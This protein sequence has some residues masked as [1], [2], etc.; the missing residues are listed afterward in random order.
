MGAAAG[1]AAVL[2]RRML[3]EGLSLLSTSGTDDGGGG[4]GGGGDSMRLE[5]TLRCAPD[6][7]SG[8][9]IKPDSPRGFGPAG[10][11]AA[12]FGAA[13]CTAPVVKSILMAGAA[14]RDAAPVRLTKAARVS[15][16]F[17]RC[18]CARCRR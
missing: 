15:R 11:T 9:R 12:S 17:R 18:C 5:R 10:G 6:A 14:G 8:L 3:R 2:A 13:V 16:P 1:R 7:L 4:G